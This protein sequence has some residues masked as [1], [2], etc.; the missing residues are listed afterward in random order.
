M[1]FLCFNCL[2]FSILVLRFSAIPC[3][4]LLR[5]NPVINQDAPNILRN[6]IIIAT[7]ITILA[8]GYFPK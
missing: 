7:G 3:P 2:I 6:M 1:I 5:I 8:F 4:I